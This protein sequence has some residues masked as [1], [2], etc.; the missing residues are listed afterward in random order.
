MARNLN[1]NLIEI[2]YF[3]GDIEINSTN[4]ERDTKFSLK[5]RVE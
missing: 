2:L 4:A 3:D 5:Q 1:A